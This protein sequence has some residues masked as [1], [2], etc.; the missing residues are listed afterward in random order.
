MEK[1]TSHYSLQSIK[2]L[3]S[4]GRY[5]ITRTARVDYINLGF[6]DD[7]VI[8]IIMSLVNKDLYKSMTSYSDNKIWQDVYHKT[9]DELELYIKLQITSEAIV[10]SFKEQ[11]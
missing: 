8:E 10:V 6:D 3:I 1:R 5:F 4:D 11:T 9:I 7:R 2:G